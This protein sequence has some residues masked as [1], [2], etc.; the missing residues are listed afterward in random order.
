MPCY[1]AII[2]WLAQICDVVLACIV[3]YAL[4]QSIEVK[5]ENRYIWV[6]GSELGDSSCKACIMSCS[7]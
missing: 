3:A 7:D 1:S 2:A 4:R 6:L 5:Q